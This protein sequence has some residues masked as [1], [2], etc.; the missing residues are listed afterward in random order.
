MPDSGAPPMRSNSSGRDP[1]LRVRWS[2]AI[3]GALLIVVAALAAALAGSDPA[4]PPEFQVDLQKTR[5]AV[6]RFQRFTCPAKSFSGFQLSAGNT[7]R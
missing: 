7:A 6:A 5:E 1:W 3:A 4:V 2:A